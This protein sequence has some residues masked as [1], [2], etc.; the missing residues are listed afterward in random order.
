M[1]YFVQLQKSISNFIPNDNVNLDIDLLNKVW[2]LPPKLQATESDLSTDT[3]LL[4]EEALI[5]WLPLIEGLGI[6]IG[7]DY[8]QIL[9]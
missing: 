3:V 5:I 9:I 6:T 7:G 1:S 2:I 4:F 8:Y